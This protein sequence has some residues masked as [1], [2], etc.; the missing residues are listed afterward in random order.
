VLAFAQEGTNVVL[1]D[2]DEPQARRTAADADAL[3]AGGRTLALKCDITQ[4]QQVEAMVHNALQEFG[5]VDIL[6]NNVGWAN[7]AF[8]LEEP[9]EVAEKE[10]AI[11][12]W[13]MVNCTKA[14]LP[15]MV[16]R[17]YGRVVSISSDAGRMGEFKQAI[18]AGCKAG[19]IGL[20]KTVAREVGRHG[21]TIN[22]V[23]PGTTVPQGPQD[24][25]EMSM[26]SPDSPVGSVFTPE[27]LPEF[28]RA[29]ALR[30]LGKPQDIASM[31]VFLASER[32]GHITGQTISVDGGYTMM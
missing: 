12:F 1:A 4:P 7:L 23:C 21:V 17:K 20:S 9:R 13:G 3:R 10:V 11:N 27:R 19:V 29:Y 24:I 14:V 30:K 6:V 16:E 5:K 31:V 22:V 32:A 2:I 26:W 18:Y 28:A 8:F 15:H 25:G